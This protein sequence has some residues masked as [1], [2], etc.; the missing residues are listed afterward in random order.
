MLSRDPIM[1]DALA[2]FRARFG[3][4]IAT[5]EDRIAWIRVGPIL[6]PYPNPGRFVLHDMHHILLGVR[7]DFWGELEVSAF[8]L[9]TGCPTFRIW[10]ICAA[11]VLLALI[12]SPRRALAA[13]RRF[14]HHTTNLYEQGRREA[15]LLATPLSALARGLDLPCPPPLL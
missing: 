7:P 1:R 10:F 13:W 11:C 5:P 3:T 14:A 15:E 2:A 9:R 6:I 4:N 12:A 8:E